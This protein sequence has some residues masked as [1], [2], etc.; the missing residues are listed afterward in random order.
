MAK[1]QTVAL[2]KKGNFKVRPGAL[3]RALNVPVGEKLG[4]TKIK[5]ALSSKKPEVRKMAAS[6]RGM[7]AMGKK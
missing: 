1:T 3:H 6:A 2:G 7:T 4:S 5:S